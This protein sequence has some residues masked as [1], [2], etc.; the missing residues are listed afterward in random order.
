MKRQAGR[1]TID[2]HARASGEGNFVCTTRWDDG[3]VSYRPDSLYALSLNDD[4]KQHSRIG[5]TV[6]YSSFEASTLR[7]HFAVS[8]ITAGPTHG[9]KRLVWTSALSQYPM[10]C[11]LPDALCSDRHRLWRNVSYVRHGVR[12]IHVPDKFCSYFVSRSA[13]ASRCAFRAAALALITS[14]SSSSSL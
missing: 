4:L 12:Y 8:H 3:Q 13:L 7:F 5:S 2:A 11:A 9:R 1:R 14:I 10:S 6:Q